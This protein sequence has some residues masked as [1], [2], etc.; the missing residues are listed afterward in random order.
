MNSDP[1]SP[2]Q[3]TPTAAGGPRIE[4]PPHMVA[5]TQAA[6]FKKIWATGRPATTSAL[7]ALRSRSRADIET[8]LAWLAER[9]RARLDADGNVIG[10]AGLSVIPTRHHL[11]NGDRIRHTWCAIDALGILAAT[12]G[13]GRIVSIPPGSRDTVTVDFHD[14]QPAPTEAVVFV[15]ND[16]TCASVV[17]HWC[18][19]VNLFPTAEAARAWQQSNGASGEIVA[20]ETAA[21][22]ASPRWQPL[23]S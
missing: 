10:I 19:Q 8:D 14:G 16:D 17:D 7:A 23:F 2:R 22:T 11:I 4:P 5:A 13:D 12:G 1:T 3:A 21:S 9:G 18:P 20:V 6:A 15:L